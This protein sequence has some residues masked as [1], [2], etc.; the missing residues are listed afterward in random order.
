[1]TW[2]TPFIKF[3]VDDLIFGKGFLLFKPDPS[4]ESTPTFITEPK[5]G[6]CVVIKGIVVSALGSGLKRRKPLP[7]IKS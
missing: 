4:A 1:M 7:N 2:G 3:D 5:I 6:F